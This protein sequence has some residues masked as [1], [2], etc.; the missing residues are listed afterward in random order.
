[1]VTKWY[2]WL[3]VDINLSFHGPIK[4]APKLRYKKA[5]RSL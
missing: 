2:P 4:E 1:M 3:W 5:M